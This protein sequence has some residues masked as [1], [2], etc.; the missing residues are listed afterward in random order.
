MQSSSIQ[1]E[2]GFFTGPCLIELSS[3]IGIL[4]DHLPFVYGKLCLKSF[5]INPFYMFNVYPD[6]PFEDRCASNRPAASGE[7]EITTEICSIGPAPLAKTQCFFLNAISVEQMGD[8]SI[9]QCG[10]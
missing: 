5:E 7:V 10:K 8:Q 3:W 2:Y 6:T 1:L 4:H 9:P